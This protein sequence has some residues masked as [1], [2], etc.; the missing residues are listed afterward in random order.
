M[1]SVAENLEAWNE[2]YVWTEQGDE[3]SAEFGGTDAMWWFILYPRLHY[4]LPTGRI[5]EIAPGCGR[6]T[7]FLKAHC[8]SLIG[9]DVSS[10]CV[11]H[12]RGRFSADT[13]VEFH[14]NDGRSL[15]IVSD[16]SVDFVFSFDSLVHAENDVV[17]GYLRQLSKKLRPGGSGFIHHSNLGA[18]PGRLSLL[19]YYDDLPSFVRRRILSQERLEKVLSINFGGWRARSMTAALFRRYCNDAGLRCVGQELFSWYKGKCLIDAISVIAKADADANKKAACLENPEF[20][21]SA[22][23]TSRLSQLYCEAR[24]RDHAPGHKR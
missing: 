3:W 19:R 18:Y 24:A 15:S 14:V 21:R 10:K 22:L 13:H 11:E 2:R 12:C 17:E 7:Q 23:S 4:F 5:L 9:I 16:N 1:P 8:S 6:W 20:I